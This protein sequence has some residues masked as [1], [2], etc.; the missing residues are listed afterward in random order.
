MSQASLEKITV[1]C[2]CG[3]NLKAPASAAGRNAKCPKCGASLLI[4]APEQLKPA[5]AAEVSWESIL[6]LAKQERKQAKKGSADSDDVV[7]PSCQN[8][9]GSGGVICTN[10][11]YNTRTDRK[12]QTVTILQDKDGSSANGNRAGGAANGHA[13]KGGLLSFFRKRK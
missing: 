1:P 3:A 8:K 11:G 12:L 9:L 2:A 5:S 7:C 6:L 10:C 13:K 4:Q